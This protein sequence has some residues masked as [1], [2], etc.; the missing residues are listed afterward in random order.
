MTARP[1]AFDADQPDPYI[2]ACALHRV[3]DNFPS[4]YRPTGADEALKRLQVRRDSL[5][6]AQAI[7]SKYGVHTDAELF[8]ELNNLISAIPPGPTNLERFRE[9]L[10][11]I[12]CDLEDEMSP[13]Q[14]EPDGHDKSSQYDAQTVGVRHRNGG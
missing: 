10:V 11:E 14:P 8:A 3:P 2:D 13:V 9:A 4:W 7:R 1:A 6:A 12:A 5:K